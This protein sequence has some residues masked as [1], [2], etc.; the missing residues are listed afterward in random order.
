MVE[1][2]DIPKSLLE[3]ILDEMF[4][5]LEKRDEFDSNAIHKL[6]Q[7]ASSGNLT[8]QREVTEAIRFT[9]EVFHESA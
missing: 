7:L 9:S 5:N 8:K 4:A 2:T 3:Q 1:R 6:R